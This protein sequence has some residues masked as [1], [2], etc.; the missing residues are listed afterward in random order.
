MEM[1]HAN[2][3]KRTTSRIS[4]L[5]QLTEERA[6]RTAVGSRGRITRNE[7]SP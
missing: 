5:A 1:R 3:N 7:W 4:Q 6:I 2:T